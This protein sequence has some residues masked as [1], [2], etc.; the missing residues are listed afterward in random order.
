[1]RK[2][3][4]T[5]RHGGITDVRTLSNDHSVGSFVFIFQSQLKLIFQI[6]NNF[7]ES[8][9]GIFMRRI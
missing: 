7:K 4:L 9:I 3:I 8:Q 1:M 2:I 6:L 5:Q